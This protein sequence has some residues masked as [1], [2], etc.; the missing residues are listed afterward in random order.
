MEGHD[1]SM[2]ICKIDELFGGEILGS[3]VMA[4]DYQV[5]LAK[6]TII[7]NEYIEKLKELG[8]VKVYIQDDIDT[9]EVVVLK[10]EIEENFKDIVKNVIEKHTYCHSD[11]LVELTKTADNIFLSLLDQEEVVEKIYDIKERSCD[12]YEH[13]INVCALAILTALKMKIPHHTIHDIG[14]SSLLHDLGLRYLTFDYKNQSLERLTNMEMAEYKKHPVYG[15]SVLKNESW[16]S[17]ISK[18]IILY[19]HEHI[20]GSGYPLRANDI[21]IEARI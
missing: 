17:D 15:Y 9:E 6:G 2:R 21:S 10:E 5:L 18:N 4:S 11:E 16:I 14:V 19:H 12:I 8:I 20:D 7:K 1:C 13:S 3:D